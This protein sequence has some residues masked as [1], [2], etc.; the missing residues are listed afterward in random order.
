[1]ESGWL[2]W[3]GNGNQELQ[4]EFSRAAFEKFGS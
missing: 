4:K 3:A 2:L 1:M